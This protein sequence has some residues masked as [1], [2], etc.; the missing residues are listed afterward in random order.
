M[1]GTYQEKCTQLQT[2]LEEQLV[3]QG[4][5][6]SLF[7]NVENI[8][9]KIYL[10]LESQSLLKTEIVIETN[11]HADDMEEAEEEI[12]DY[13]HDNGLNNGLNEIFGDSIVQLDREVSVTIV[14]Q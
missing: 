6:H 11:G 3:S 10:S 4:R 2:I 5:L 1:A 8:Y 13:V 9:I 12:N 14:P 7:K